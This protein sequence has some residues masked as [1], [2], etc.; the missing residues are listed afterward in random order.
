MA[1]QSSLLTQK[2]NYDWSALRQASSGQEPV[3]RPAQPVVSMVSAP[4]SAPVPKPD[5][6]IQGLGPAAQAALVSSIAEEIIPIVTERLHAELATALDF[7]LRNAA[8]RVRGDI[9][10]NLDANLRIAI[11]Q[12]VSRRARGA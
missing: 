12:A 5:E 4:V 7:A 11:A 2:V 8:Q 6:V 1:S 10:R 9:E 3:E